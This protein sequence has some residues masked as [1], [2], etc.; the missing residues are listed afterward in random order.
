MC[1]IQVSL[2]QLP[3]PWVEG[4]A[5]ETS[6]TVLLGATHCQTRRPEGYL[7]ASPP[8][9]SVSPNRR[10]VSA[11]PP[12]FRLSSFPQAPSPLAFPLTFSP[13][14]PSRVPPFFSSSLSSLPYQVNLEPQSPL[15]LPPWD[16]FP[17]LWELTGLLP[18]LPSLFGVPARQLPRPSPRGVECLN[19]PTFPF[20][21]P[22]RLPLVS[23]RWRPQPDSAA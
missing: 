22:K 10:P 21:P 4:V 17:L 6:V 11:P 7:P 16:R 8:P 2:L 9:H 18:S 3:R 20:N 19:F 5:L 14:A 1:G 13:P 23:P 15:F 12:L